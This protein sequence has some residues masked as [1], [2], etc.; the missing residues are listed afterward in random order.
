MLALQRGVEGNKK[1]V[2][3]TTKRGVVLV[4]L[5]EPQGYWLSNDIIEARER[6]LDHLCSTSSRCFSFCSAIG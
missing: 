6:N 2:S 1:R 5:S 3:G 4:Q